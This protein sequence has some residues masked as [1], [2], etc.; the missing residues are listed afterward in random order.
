MLLNGQRIQWIGDEEPN[1]L[2]LCIQDITDRLDMEKSLKEAIAESKR[3]DQS[4][5]V[6]LATLSHELRTP[7]T[8]I[9]CWAQLLLKM[10]EGSEKLKHGLKAIEQN[11][12]IQGQLIDDLLDV[13][14]IQSGKLILSISHLDPGEVVRTAVESIRHL[15]ESKSLTIKTHIKSL[16]GSVAADPARLQQII[17]NLLTNA[18]KF[19]PPNKVI[20]VRV[21]AVDRTRT[22]LCCNRSH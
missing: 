22:T 20:D 15:A 2:L 9:L 17:W 6:F 12:K 3:A 8:A 4:K 1:A 10:E 13:S 16:N 7:L 18:I 19:S 21:N 14:R 11:S 5:D